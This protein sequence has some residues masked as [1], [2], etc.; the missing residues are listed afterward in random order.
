MRLLED[1]S[2]VGLTAPEGLLSLNKDSLSEDLLHN[3]IYRL[4]SALTIPEKVRKFYLY[5]S[6][7]AL[8]LTWSSCAQSSTSANGRRWQE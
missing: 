3:G 2:E 5:L 7:N 1:L 8:Y 4:L 6:S